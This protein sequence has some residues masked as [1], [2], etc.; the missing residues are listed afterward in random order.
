VTSWR[1]QLT[2]RTHQGVCRGRNAG[3][4][5][6][7]ASVKNPT[8]PAEDDA[9]ART[10]ISTAD[11][12][13]PPCSSTSRRNTQP[14]ARLEY[15]LDQIRDRRVNFDL[16][17]DREKAPKKPKVSVLLAEL[18]ERS[19]RLALVEDKLKQ[20]VNELTAET[21]RADN[22]ARE[23]IARDAPKRQKTLTHFFRPNMHMHTHERAHAHARAHE[24]TRTRTRAHAHRREKIRR[25]SLVRKKNTRISPVSS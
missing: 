24:C 12:I 22:L 5:R 19:S 14:P 16:A 7:C 11:E 9:G 6:Q 25:L 3:E 1:P 20:L 15:P 2:T 4:D 21:R 8:R 13:D 17:M 18:A 23:K 10:A